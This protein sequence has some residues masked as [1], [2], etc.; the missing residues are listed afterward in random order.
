MDLSFPAR[1]SVN[2]GIK[3]E[4]FT[5]SYAHVVDAV[6]FIISEGCGTLLTKIDIRGA[7]R[8]I[9]IHPEDRPLLGISWNDNIYV[10]LALPFGLR[11]APFIFNQFA[12]V[13]LPVGLR[14]PTSKLPQMLRAQLAT[15]PSSMGTGSPVTG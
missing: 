13:P 2:D 15:A 6:N 7:Y 1:H 5:L 10:D 12:S 9:P 8:L 4:D 14:Y 11:S 3:R